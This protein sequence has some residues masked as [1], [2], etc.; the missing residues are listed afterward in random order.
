MPEWRRL[1]KYSQT[2]GTHTVSA[3]KVKGEWKY[4]LWLGTGQVRDK[5]IAVF[6]S[7]EEARLASYDYM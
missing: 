6:N 4:T 7:G 2:N 3:C 1:S 5:R